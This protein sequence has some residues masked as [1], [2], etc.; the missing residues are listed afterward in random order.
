MLV[1][2]R[3]QLS[4]YPDVN[5]AVYMT[6]LQVPPGLGQSEFFYSWVV[7]AFSIGEVTFALVYTGLYN[8]VPYTYVF[9][10]LIVS[11]ILGYLLYAVASSGWEILVARFLI[12][13]LSV[14]GESAFY[15]YV[16]EREVDYEIAYYA[17]RGRMDDVDG[18]K[19][20]KSLKEKM[21]AYRTVGTGTA[22]LIGT[23]TLVSSL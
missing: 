6:S 18:S 9:L 3:S 8:V 17:T 13:G 16:A 10:S 14:L 5:L 21:Y 2:S 11:Y 20:P 1:N 15:V 19:K 23:G 7:T 22:F 4:V 12:G